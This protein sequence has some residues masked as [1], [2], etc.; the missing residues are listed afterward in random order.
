MFVTE[1]NKGFDRISVEEQAFA[2]RRAAA[3]A[4]TVLAMT[5]ARVDGS[6]YY[7]LWDQVCFFEQFQPFSGTLASC[8]ALE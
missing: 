2:P 1:W 3:A 8:T 6:F 5:D 7:H 4:A